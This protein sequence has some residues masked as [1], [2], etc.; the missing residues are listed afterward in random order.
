MVEETVTNAAKIIHHLGLRECVVHNLFELF[1]SIWQ[2][3]HSNL[4]MSY[5]FLFKVPDL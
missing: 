1:Q 3:V 2:I 5:L 4:M